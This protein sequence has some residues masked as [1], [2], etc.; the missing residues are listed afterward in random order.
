MEKNSPLSLVRHSPGSPFLS[1]K[2]KL[3]LLL[4]AVTLF[5]VYYWDIEI[6]KYIGSFRFF[7]V[8][9]FL[10]FMTNR[11]LFFASLLFSGYLLVKKKY[12][13]FILIIL[14][15]MLTFETGFL[16]KKILHVP[17]PY[18]R[19]ILEETI[20]TYAWGYSFPSLHAAF[21]FS[22]LPYLK[23]IFHSLFFVFLGIL[24]FIIVIFSR[25]SLGVHYLS[26][27]VA[28]A[29]LGYISAKFWLYLQANY[30]IIEWLSGHFHAKLELR[31]QIAHLITGIITIALLKFNLLNIHLLVGLLV[32]G[33]TLSIIIKK[34]P[35]PFIYPALKYFERPKDMKIFPGKGPLFFVLGSIVSLLLFPERTAFA[36]I[37]IM[38][39]GDSITT[40]IG[41]YF[42]KIKYPYNKAKHVE[43]TMMAIIFS[44]LAAYSFVDFPKAFMASTAAMIFE[45]FTIKFID[46]SLDDNLFIPIIAG[47]VI[48]GM[49]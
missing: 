37:A 17:R 33:M 1:T 23:K 45:S 25:I 6:F 34:Y 5:V 35:I 15:L 48:L 47:L 39:V 16:M 32:L 18:T 42:G 26:D 9:E 12:H 36:A 38:A 49:S 20:L 24:L 44:T 43:G 19:Q 14:T 7:Y 41:L 30:H 10:L 27:L 2:E 13:E 3:F 22:I 31:R 28:G 29:L 11:G 40:I 46:R 21:C 8:D 4:G